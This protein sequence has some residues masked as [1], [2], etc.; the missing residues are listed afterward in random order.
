MFGNC[1][2]EGGG[3]GVGGMGREGG[4]LSVGVAGGGRKEEDDG[5][6]VHL[7][8]VVTTGDEAE[9]ARQYA[10]CMAALKRVVRVEWW[11]ER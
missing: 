3:G 5:M 9:S 1:G 7:V 10:R 11:R 8:C 6:C 2:C 4:R